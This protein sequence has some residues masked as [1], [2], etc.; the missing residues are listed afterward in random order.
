VSGKDTL[1]W[2]WAHGESTAAAEFGNPDVSTAYAFCLFDESAVTPELVLERIVPAGSNWSANTKGFKYK[3]V[4]GSGGI[5]K[6]LLK[7]GDDFKAKILVKGKGDGLG[8][9]SVPVDQ[10]SSVRVQLLTDTGC[11][12][13]HY[14][15]TGNDPGVFK[16]KSD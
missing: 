13:A 1:A 12:E 3:A 2:R 7:S 11:W 10:L 16:A 8:L 4:G 6:T 15:S 14:T 9:S 5:T